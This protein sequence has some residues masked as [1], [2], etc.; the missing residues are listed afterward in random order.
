MIKELDHNRSNIWNGQKSTKTIQIKSARI[1]VCTWHN[2][3][4]RVWKYQMPWHERLNPDLCC[5]ISVININSKISW[6]SAL[7]HFYP[8]TVHLMSDSDR[9]L[10]TRLM[11]THLRVEG[12]WSHHFHFNSQYQPDI[13]MCGDWNAVNYHYNIL[14][15][16]TYPIVDSHD[17]YTCVS[18]VVVVMECLKCSFKFN[19]YW[20][21]TLPR[22]PSVRV[23]WSALPR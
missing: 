1:L 6:S 18:V 7:Y 3:C 9:T 4:R 17:K 13:G 21:R 8:N 2:V 12:K 11:K 23:P 22:W 10:H 16:N 20:A 19:Y 5:K 14:L 15:F